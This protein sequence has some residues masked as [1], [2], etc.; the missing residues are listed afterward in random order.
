MH[1]RRLKAD[2][3]VAPHHGSSTS[4]INDFVNQVSPQAVIFTVGKDNR[5][6]F[7]K[8]EVLD[9]YKAVKSQIYRTDSDGAVTFYSNSNDFRLESQ[10]RRHPRLWH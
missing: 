9:R 3:L 7:P 8:S 10:R 1:P 2:L 4:S 5:W 6:R